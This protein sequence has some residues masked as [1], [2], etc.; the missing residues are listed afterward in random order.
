MENSNGV[1][2]SKLFV[3]L[4]VLILLALVVFLSWV[5]FVKNKS[6]QAQKS[7]SVVYL[8]SGEVYVGKLSIFPRISL[9]EAYLLQIVQDPKDSSKS[10]FRLNPLKDSLWSPEK[11]YLNR[12]QII[13]YGK[14]GE[15]SKIAETMAQAK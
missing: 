1:N 12:D 8:A 5:A 13:F 3:G 9:S 11:V 15:G 4:I 7:Y 10:S 2:K 6:N 14:V